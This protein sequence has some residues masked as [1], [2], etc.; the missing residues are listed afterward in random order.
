MR[1]AIVVTGTERGLGREI[2]RVL[3]E[4]G[5]H[6]IAVSISGTE[7]EK[8]K[9][10]L[11]GSLQIPMDRLDVIEFDLRNVD[12]IGRLVE[13]IKTC[14]NNQTIYLWG[15]VN[16]AAI[17][18]PSSG[19]SSLLVDMGLKDMMEVLKVNMI[20]AFLISREMFKLIKKTQK[21]GAIVL[22]SSIS[23]VK[24]SPLLPVYAMTK[25][26][27][28]NLAKSIAVVGGGKDNIRANAIS[29]GVMLTKMAADIFPTKE[30]IQERFQKN[31]IQRA[32][33][34]A[35]VA[36]LVSYLLSDYAGYITG[37]NIEISGGRRLL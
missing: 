37:E 36:H 19:R 12:K 11:V 14:L 20:A 23:G 28:A 10:E 15:Y 34:P 13:A 17:G 5:Y 31:I 30:K 22:I 7:M 32:C 21:G 3:L 33:D 27:L 26:A 16:N 4:E 24:G 8:T 1:R 6:I 35:E 2:S 18:E 25:A 9:K 29:P